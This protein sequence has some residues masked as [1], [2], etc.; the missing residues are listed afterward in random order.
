[1]GKRVFVVFLVILLLTTSVYAYSFTEFLKDFNE[2]VSGNVVG[3]EVVEDVDKCESMFLDKYKCEDNNLVRGYQKLDCSIV[4]LFFKDCENGCS[5]GRCEE[6]V[7]EVEVLDVVE[8]VDEGAIIIEQENVDVV[9]EF[10]VGAL[11]QD[12]EIGVGVGI[13]GQLD[14]FDNVKNMNLYSEKN[15][16]LI[17]DEDWKDVLPLVP[18]TTWT[19]ENGDIHKYPT[20]VYHE[21]DSF[22]L[23]NY[24]SLNTVSVTASSTYGPSSPDNIIDEDIETAW[25]NG[26]STEAWLL[27][28]LIDLGILREINQIKIFNDADY[29][30]ITLSVSSNNVDFQIIESN[31][32]LDFGWNLFDFDIIPVNG[33]RYIKIEL[34]DQPGQITYP[35]WKQIAEVKAFNTNEGSFVETFDADSVIHFMQLYELYDE[36]VLTIVG[37]V[38]D[39]LADLLVADFDS[40]TKEGGAGLDEDQ[41]EYITSNDYFNYWS[42]YGSIVWVQD[43]YKFSLLAS[44][45]ASYLNAPLVI[46]PQLSGGSSYAPDVGIVSGQQAT[47]DVVIENNLKSIA[48]LIF[49]NKHVIIVGNMG[50]PSN[51]ESC[52]FFRTVEEIQHDYIE[53]T[54]TDKLLITNPNDISSDIIQEY[55][56]LEK[57]SGVLSHIY[58][59]HSL[60]APLLASGKH[61]LIILDDHVESQNPIQRW[62]DW[63]T[64]DDLVEYYMEDFFDNDAEY[65][66]ILAPP[67]MIVHSMQMLGSLTGEGERDLY[68]AT[69]PD[70]TG[71]DFFLAPGRIYSVTSSDVSSYIARSLFYDELIDNIYDEEEY[72]AFTIG[73]ECYGPGNADAMRDVRDYLESGGYDIEQTLC[74]TYPENPNGCEHEG[75]FLTSPEEQDYLRNKQF[76]QFS[77]HGG[78]IGWENALFSPNIP[79]LDLPVTGGVLACSTNN[80]YGFDSGDLAYKSFGANMLRK[81]AMSYTGSIPITFNILWQEFSKIFTSIVG[82]TLGHVNKILYNNFWTYYPNHFILLGDPTLSPKFKYIEGFNYECYDFIDNDGDNLIDHEDPDCLTFISFED[83]PHSQCND[84]IDNDGDG[85][86][87]YPEDIGCQS[88]D[89]NSEDFCGDSITQSLVLEEN[90]NCN[91]GDGLIINAN[92]I[93]LDCDN[94][95]ITS[96]DGSFGVY[97]GSFSNNVTIKN[98]IIRN[99][100]IGIYLPVFG[101]DIHLIFNDIRYNEQGVTI[102]TLSNFELTS[103]IIL[104]NEEEDISCLD[105]DGFYSNGDNICENIE[106]YDCNPPVTCIPP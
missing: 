1:M 12:G 39:E 59:K 19:D 102:D 20:L 94:Y 32:I 47:G 84:W 97:I 7:V 37:E 68:Y 55:P 16:F 89:D 53:K 90:L 22:I 103:N 48:P 2:F 93:I 66:T 40:V 63:E 17:S 69:K 75:G 30:E 29:Y 70:V 14:N 24:A 105:S 100:G 99:F 86:M 27:I 96:I 95:F 57:S 72:T 56:Y 98:C 25:N 6:K 50:C 85:Y 61:E 23:K 41:I 18:V 4:Y 3:R 26:A 83:G 73:R 45:T 64:T 44:V 65:L 36:G 52:E 87:D 71:E 49:D 42:S 51:A 91:Y 78:P 62:P 80:F 77:D 88:I 58:G 34:F 10:E 82:E 81:G 54:N 67:T 5:D 46:G 79:W 15:V 33:V 31:Y 60:I 104:D 13:G 8:S 35:N 11:E 92:D 21:D 9:E 43:D 76:I 28:D 106:N 38:P 74:S 101:E